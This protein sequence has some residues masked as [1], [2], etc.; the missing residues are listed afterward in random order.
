MLQFQPIQEKLH[1]IVTKDL[2]C[3]KLALCLQL[4]N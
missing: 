1:Q 3:L 4:H 2:I